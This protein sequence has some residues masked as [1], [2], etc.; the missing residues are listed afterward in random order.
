MLYTNKLMPTSSRSLFI[1][2]IKKILFFL[3]LILITGIT[4]EIAAR[5]IPHFDPFLLFIPVI[6]YCAMW[7]GFI[8]G[9]VT[10]SICVL[11]VTLML[12]YPA[13]HPFFVA[14]ISFF[15]QVCILLFCRDIYQLSYV[16]G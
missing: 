7:G 8:I 15:I 2:P 10:T 1:P 11:I 16:C 14:D 4:A 12:F 6:A 3:G 5:Y 9:F 13:T